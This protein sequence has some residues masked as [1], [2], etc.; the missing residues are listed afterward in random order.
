MV[1]SGGRGVD[2]CGRSPRDHHPLTRSSHPPRYDGGGLYRPARITVRSP[3][4]VRRWGVYAA[5]TVDPATIR[6]AAG[7]L[8]A[9]A[10]LRVATEVESENTDDMK[11]YQ[12]MTT[13][14]GPE[15]GVVAEG[16]VAADAAPDADGIVT[17]VQTW[18]LTDLKLWDVAN[19]SSSAAYEPNLYTVVTQLKSAKGTVDD[20]TN[21]TFGVR[22]TAWDADTGFYLNGNPVKIL[23]TANHQDI[24]GVGVAV[25]DVS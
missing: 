4:H 9:S 13:I 14:L 3:V 5:A 24:F 17:A 12:V 2:A 20:T 1:V 21:S 16:T 18:D 7:G 6:G 22:H 19:L 25:P 11:G 23:G 10:A 8:T 15:G